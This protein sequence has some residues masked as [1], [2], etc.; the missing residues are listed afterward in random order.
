MTKVFYFKFIAG[1]SVAMALT[2]AVSVGQDWPQ[3]RGPNRDGIASSFTP[4][5]AWP[6]KL[7]TVWKIQVGTGHSC[8]VVAGHRV[9]LLSRQAESEVASCFDVDTGKVLWRDSYPVGYEMN[10]AA[11][12]HGKGPKSTSVVSDDRL[13]TLGIAGVLSCY[14]TATGKLRWRKEF[15]K[16]FKTTSPDFGTAASP[17]VWNGMLIAHVGGHDSGA[18]MAFDGNT[19]EVRWRWNG[20]GPGYASPVIAEIGGTSQI[21]TQTQKSIAGF[22]AQTGELLWQIPFET[23]YVQNIVTPVVYKQTLILSGIDKGTMAIRAVKR[24]KKWETERIWDNQEVS[25]YM[26]SPVVR[27]DYVFGFSHKRKGQFFC[28]DARTGKTLWT[29]NGR[30]GDNAAIVGADQYLF[31]LTDGADLIVA[32]NNPKQFEVLKKY[33]VAESPTWAHPVIVGN[34]VLIKDASTLALLSLQ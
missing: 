3:W 24:A 17:I 5:T 7:K 33:S 16:Q 29:D 30:D 1:V 31:L 20:D 25:M 15:A 34:G 4:P 6:E 18:L 21:V 14:D 9:Y 13:Y 23:E 8:P 27:G 32:R 26:S 28:I 2:G 22:A 11:V 19:G 10:P 12:S